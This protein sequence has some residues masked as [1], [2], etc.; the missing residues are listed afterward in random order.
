MKKSPLTKQEKLIRKYKRLRKNKKAKF[1][2]TVI[3]PSRIHISQ[4]KFFLILMPF[5]VVT[6]LPLIYIVS[7]AFKPLDELYAYPPRIFASRL[8]LDNF[9][10]LFQ[11]ASQTGVSFLRY[12]FNSFLSSFLVITLSILI[13]SLAAYSFSFLKY[14]IKNTL[15]FFNQLAIMVVPI[16]VSVPRFIVLSQLGITNTFFAHVIPLL[17]MPVGVFLVKQFMDQVPREL[18]EASLIDGANKW[19]IYAK[20]VMPLVKP[21][22][23]TIAILAFQN[24]WNNMETSELYINQEALRTLPYYFSTLTFNTSSIAA[25]GM[26][27]AA[28]LLLFLPNILLFI[29]LQNQ[30]M[31][32]MAHSGIK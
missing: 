7:H 6:L 29:V 1:L 23:A 12:L 31:N 17:A 2:G 30:V 8:T 22:L 4:L 28:S 10:N 20:V 18:Y 13:G 15:F 9:Q 19:Q 24:S 16:A 32:T 11:A 27:A 26:S 21:A 14:K 25:Q 3:N 5:I